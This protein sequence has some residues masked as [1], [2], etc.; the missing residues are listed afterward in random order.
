MDKVTEN[1]LAIIDTERSRYKVAVAI[2][3]YIAAHDLA[4]RKELEE[5]IGA[6]SPE[7]TVQEGQDDWTDYEAKGANAEKARLREAVARVMG[8]EE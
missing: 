6:N 4:K 1:I 3:G 5:A 8:D 2:T 7:V